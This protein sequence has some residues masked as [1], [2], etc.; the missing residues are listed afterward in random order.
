[1]A[2]TTEN[3]ERDLNS[4]ALL[5]LS[6]YEKGVFMSPEDRREFTSMLSYEEASTASVYLLKLMMNAYALETGRS[7]EELAAHVRGILLTDVG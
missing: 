2:D 6:F 1:M 4:N 3:F 5:M 7:P